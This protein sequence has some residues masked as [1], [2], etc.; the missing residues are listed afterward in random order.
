MYHENTQVEYE[1]GSG[2]IIF[3]R[4][5]PLALKKIQ[6]ISG[7]HSLS[8]SF[9]DI[10]N[11]N[12]E[13]TC[14]TRI[15]RSSS[16]MVLF[17]LFSAM[18]WPCTYVS[19]CWIIFKKSHFYT[20]VFRGDILWYDD[21]RPGLHPSLFSALFS[22]MLWDIELKFGVSLYFDAHKIKLECHQFP[23]IFAGVMP[24][25]NFKLL[26]ICSFPH[27]SPTCFDILSWKMCIWLCFN[28]YPAAKVYTSAISTAAKVRVN[29]CS[30]KDA[31]IPPI[32]PYSI[33]ILMFTI[34]NIMWKLKSKE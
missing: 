20:P 18:L 1:F 4:V 6:I 21:V 5:M 28:P 8:P 7:C 22:Y 2:W 3:G 24:L 11:W 12:S 34:I 27:F 29:K 31:H 16:D 32:S 26:Q 33:F 9:M 13:C 30:A 14:V 15:H 23:S 10:F 19:W 25:L 17:Q